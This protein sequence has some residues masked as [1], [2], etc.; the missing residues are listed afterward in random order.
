MV[1]RVSS[2]RRTNNNQQEMRHRMFK[3]YFNKMMGRGEY[4]VKLQMLPP[5]FVKEANNLKFKYDAARMERLIAKVEKLYATQKIN[6]AI[7]DRAL[8][9]R[10]F[11]NYLNQMKNKS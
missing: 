2:I 5:P 1:G 3:N 7:S 10:Q 8:N 4:S 11:L 6:P 9:T